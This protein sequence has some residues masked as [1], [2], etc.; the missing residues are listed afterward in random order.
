VAEARAAAVG[1]DDPVA[2]AEEDV[3]DAVAVQVREPRR[4]L[5]VGGKAAREAGH[6]VSVLVQEGAAAV[7]AGAIVVVAHPD[8]DREREPVRVAVAGRDV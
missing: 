6:R 7:L 3:V 8:A 1:V 5:A 4:A 2:R